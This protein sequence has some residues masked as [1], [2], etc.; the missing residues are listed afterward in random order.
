[1]EYRT[2]E[3]AKKRDIRKA[4]D[5]RWKRHEATE[6]DHHRWFKDKERKVNARREEQERWKCGKETESDKQR[7]IK[8]R[9]REKKRREDPDERAWENLRKRAKRNKERDDK[10]TKNEENIK[11]LNEEKKKSDEAVRMETLRIQKVELEATE[12][13][14]FER[15]AKDEQNAKK[16]ISEGKLPAHYYDKS[17]SDPPN[18]DQLAWLDI[19]VRTCARKNRWEF[20]RKRNLIINQSS[21]N[22]HYSLTRFIPFERDQWKSKPFGFYPS[23]FNYYPPDYKLGLEG[24]HIHEPE[25]PLIAVSG[26]IPTSMIS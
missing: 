22:V 24:Y 10:E 11:K 7:R 13:E 25:F 16:A 21:W 4:A 17:F 2:N 6:D 23:N 8:N 19:N 12:K 14:Y 1:M 3:S 18:K 26:Y 15:K 5:V 20:T 9:E